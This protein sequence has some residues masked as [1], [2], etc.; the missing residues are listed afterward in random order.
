MSNLV[1]VVIPTYNYHQ[2]VVEAVES[3]L[4]QTYQP[5]EIIVV[6][7][8]STDGTRAELERFEGRIRYL[9][10]ENRGLPAARN[11]GIRAAEGEYVALLD[12]DDLW[13][14][15]KIAKQVAVLERSP[16]VGLVF[17]GL[18]RVDVASGQSTIRH[19]PPDLRGD[20]R[21]Q[22]LQRNCVTGSAS[23]ALVRRACFDKVGLFDETLRSAEDWEMWIRISR[24]FHFDYVQEPLIILRNHGGNM[25]TRIERMHEYQMKVIQRAFQDDPVQGDRLLLR[26]TIAFFHSDTGQEYY[27]ADQYPLA[28]RH[29]VQAIALWPFEWRRY[30]FLIR[31]LI[32]AC[33][34]HS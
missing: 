27:W 18:T 13:A 10:Q 26:R 7:D 29:F 1:S 5:L 23:A 17:C 9:F 24:H 3:V 33:G 25:R 31:S 6:D 11:R 14:P 2:F 28:L 20:V 15:T 22:L 32:R 8:G 19:C 30:A 16:Q 21:R 34:G 12:A 4:A